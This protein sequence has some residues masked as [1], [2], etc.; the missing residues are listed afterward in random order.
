MKNLFTKRLSEKAVK[1]K[2]NI[3]DF[4]YLPEEKIGEFISYLDRM[5]PEV[6]KVALA[7]V[8]EFALTARVAIENVQKT[9]SEGFKS[10]DQSMNCYYAI[11]NN[12]IHS[13]M[14]R[15]E[16]PSISAEERDYISKEIIEVMKMVSEKDSENKKFVSGENTKNIVTIVGMVAMVAASIGV[17]I[18]LKTPV[19]LQ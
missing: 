17:S 9:M 7:Q 5:D 13:L 14:I 1:T 15:L 18:V 8:P 4:A 3:E 6:A 16:E 12:L 2:L 11:A 10:N 19:K